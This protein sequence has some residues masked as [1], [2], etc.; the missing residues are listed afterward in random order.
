[1]YICYTHYTSSLRLV[2]GER[3]QDCAAFAQ[4]G[5]L[6]S[7]AVAAPVCVCVCVCVCVLVHVC[8]CVCLCV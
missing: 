6:P 4:I 7:F 2:V 8:V 5:L 3:Q 1:M